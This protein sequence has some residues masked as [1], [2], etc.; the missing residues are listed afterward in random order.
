MQK[1]YP[2][3]LQPEDVLFFLHI[4]KT[5]GTSLTQELTQYWGA[6]STLTPDQL[7]T[8]KAQ[9][10]QRLADAKF[11]YGHFSRAVCRR[12]LPN[13]PTFTITFLRDPVDHFLSLY[14]H[15]Q[16]DANFAYTTRITLGDRELSHHI[17]ALARTGSLADF[18]ATAES[19][20]FSNFQS[21]Y[22]V[23][24]MRFQPDVSERP[25]LG[26]LAEKCLLELGAFGI[27]DHYE[28][29]LL[30]IRQALGLTGSLRARITNI[31][32]NRHRDAAPTPDILGEIN[33]RTRYDRELFETAMTTFKARLEASSASRAPERGTR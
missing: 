25:E 5:A 23:R 21:R 17:S 16:R 33:S 14:H 30:L 27:T 22:L 7:N 32:P 15:L 11:I 31:A 3:Q 19:Q 29:S 24:G 2:Q 28:D 9:P 4:P 8:A 10:R 26:V 12:R 1:S 6:E 13:P 20:L 18:L